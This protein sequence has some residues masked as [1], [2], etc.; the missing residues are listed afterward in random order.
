MSTGKIE[1][2]DKT[3]YK[4]LIDSKAQKPQ[5]NCGQV[6]GP[7]QMTFS[8]S[9]E[10]VVPIEYSITRVALTNV[11]DTRKE[12]VQTDEGEKAGSGQFGKKH[13]IPYGLYRAEGYVS[14]FI[15]EQTGFKEAD[16]ELL[17]QALINMLEHDHS[18]ARGKMSARK[19]IVFKHDSQLG[20]APAHKLFE[21]VKV[22]RVGDASKPA[23]AFAD[24]KIDVNKT[25]PHGVT[26][27]EKL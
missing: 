12:A 25:V 10:A 2:E 26:I 6:R 18:A 23:R 11:S 16:L 13:I 5:W 17:W 21:L 15:A 7:V 8:R 9:V 4:E 3:K 19:L 27:E 14:A 1:G 20:N 22:F 24:Y